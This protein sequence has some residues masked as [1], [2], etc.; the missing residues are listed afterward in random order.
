MLGKGAFKYYISPMEGAWRLIK[1][2]DA[3]GALRGSAQMKRIIHFIEKSY[4]FL[5][6]PNRIF[7]YSFSVKP[8]P[9]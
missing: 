3:A 7:Q 2:A 6:N 4:S 1:I 5:T 9:K 8:K